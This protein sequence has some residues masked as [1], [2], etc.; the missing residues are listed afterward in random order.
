MTEP[1]ESEPRDYQAAWH[2]CCE[3][4][5]REIRYRRR[6]ERQTVRMRPLHEHVAAMVIPRNTPAVFAGTLRRWRLKA[7]ETLA[8][9]EQAERGEF[10]DVDNQDL[11]PPP[12]ERAI[13]EAVP[14]LEAI[15]EWLATPGTIVETWLGEDVSAI[16]ADLRRALDGVPPPS[17]KLT[18]DVA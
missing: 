18:G 3:A 15:A 2:H 1:I 7:G 5:H 9:C 14:K 17:E 11:T 8:Y 6:L 16:V 13:C 10:D 12:Y 4:L